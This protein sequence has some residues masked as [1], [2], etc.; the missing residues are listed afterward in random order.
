[1]SEGFGTRICECGR[2]AMPYHHL[3]GA[4]YMAINR[5]EPRPAPVA[6]AVAAAPALSTQ[7]A[8]VEPAAPQPPRPTPAAAARQAPTSP[9]E[10]DDG[11]PAAV[12]GSAA[13]ESPAKPTETARSSERKVTPPRPHVVSLEDLERRGRAARTKRP[14]KPGLAAQPLPAA[15][16]PAAKGAVAPSA[17]HVPAGKGASKESPL[18]FYTIRP[19]REEADLDLTGDGDAH[20]VHGRLKSVAFLDAGRLPADP[21]EI[22]KRASLSAAIF[23]RAWPKVSKKW[24]LDASESF[25]FNPELSEEIA[26][27]RELVSKRSAAGKAGAEQLWNRKA[28]EV[29]RSGQTHDKGMRLPP[30][31]ELGTRNEELRQEG[32]GTATTPPEDQAL[33]GSRAKGPSLDVTLEFARQEA[34]PETSARRYHGNRAERGWEG[35]RDWKAGLRA[36]AERDA[37]KPLGSPRAR[38]RISSPLIGRSSLPPPPQRVARDPFAPGVPAEVRTAA[39]KRAAFSAYEEAIVAGVLDVPKPEPFLGPKDY[40]RDSRTD[41]RVRLLEWEEGDD[42]AFTRNRTRSGGG[43]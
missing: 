11:S 43:E 7:A 12:A 15:E 16:A 23:K 42:E 26:R 38:D 2:D 41:E 9:P 32:E 36:W 39:E 21:Q 3:C 37:Q 5:G 8:P 19:H 40:G 29:G 33:S 4:C 34:I 28:L 27:V 6:S 18:D 31:R 24:P 13:S 22:R 17:A 10:A 30:D 1:M 14:A 35:I 20:A 25:R